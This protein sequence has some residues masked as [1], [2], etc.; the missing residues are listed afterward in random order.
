MTLLN[1]VHYFLHFA[2]RQHLFKKQ[3][4]RIFLQVSFLN[5]LTKP[6]LS[7]WALVAIIHKKTKQIKVNTYNVGW[8]FLKKR[9]NGHAAICSHAY[10]RVTV[11]TWYMNFMM[12]SSSFPAAPVLWNQQ[13]PTKPWSSIKLFPLSF[14]KHKVTIANRSR[15]ARMPEQLSWERTLGTQEQ[16]S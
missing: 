5:T 10:Q 4:L 15:H 9:K 2:C 7:S 11:T 14:F 3:V 6:E 8:F 12:S 16:C 13:G 1:K